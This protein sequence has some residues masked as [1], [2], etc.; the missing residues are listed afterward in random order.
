MKDSISLWELCAPRSLP[1]EFIQRLMSYLS[2]F[3]LSDLVGIQKDNISFYKWIGEQTKHELLAWV[4]EPILVKFSAFLSCFPVQMQ[5][6]LTFNMTPKVYFKGETIVPLNSLPEGVFLVREGKV[7]V[8]VRKKR[9]KDLMQFTT[10]WKLGPGNFFGENCMINRKINGQY[11]CG[12]K[13][14]RV[15]FVPRMALE[16]VFRLTYFEAI[17]VMNGWRKRHTYFSFVISFFSISF[18]IY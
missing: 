16:K 12:S 5:Y 4:L 8:Q 17:S 3:A 13:E 1:F 11:V 7:M 9:A 14:V 15:L 2:F 10:C 18:D 6:F